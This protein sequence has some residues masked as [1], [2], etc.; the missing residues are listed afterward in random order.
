MMGPMISKMFNDMRF[1]L[2][3]C[4]FSGKTDGR[5]EEFLPYDT[6][7]GRRCQLKPRRRRLGIRYK[8]PRNLIPFFNLT[9]AAAGTKLN[10]KYRHDSIVKRE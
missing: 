1:L 7:L 4:P 9:A 2:T 6:G 5:A 3:G 8:S 10:R